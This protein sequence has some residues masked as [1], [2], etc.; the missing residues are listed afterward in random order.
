MPK[1]QGGKEENMDCIRIKDLEIFGYHGAK[2]EE[3][4]LGQKFVLDIFLYANVR[5]AGQTDDLTKSIHYGHA[6]KAIEAFV[7]EHT[8][9]L[10]ER[11]AEELCFYLL[12]SIE[13]LESVRLVVKKPWAP[14]KLPLDTVSVEIERGWHQVYLSMGSNMGNRKDYLDGAVSAIKE[15][16]SIKAVQVSD[17]YNTKPYGGVSQEDFLN[18]CIALKTLY[19]PE[20][21]LEYLHRLEEKAGRKRTLR[22]GPRTL[23]LDILMYDKLILETEELVIPHA[24]MENRTFVL[25]PMCQLHKNLRHPILQKTMEQLLCELEERTASQKGQE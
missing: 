21:L 3:N 11:L 15:N 22:W 16:E 12:T 7:R 9:Q 19:T 18:G 14:V 17:Y 24:D 6:A 13:N 25:K 8:Y 2:P 5:Q 23:D 4:V 10:I 1:E 20:E